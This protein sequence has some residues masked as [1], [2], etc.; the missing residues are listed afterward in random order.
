MSIAS[1]AVN[2]GSSGSAPLSVSARSGTLETTT[3][4]TRAAPDSIIGPTAHTYEHSEV[5]NG[6]AYDSGSL[7]PYEYKITTSDGERFI[8]S[9]SPG[10]DTAAYSHMF[11]IK[12]KWENLLGNCLYIQWEN[13][14]TSLSPFW[15]TSDSVDRVAEEIECKSLEMRKKYLRTQFIAGKPTI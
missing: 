14:P 2:V 7:V 3:D 6:N 1:T 11:S 15:P 5:I 13:K 10:R 8:V 9:Q 4:K 12:V